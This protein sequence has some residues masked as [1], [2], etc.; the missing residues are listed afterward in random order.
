M[1]SRTPRLRIW[2]RYI[3][4]GDSARSPLLHRVPATE[5]HGGRYQAA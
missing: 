2:R 1:D 5:V 4:S 3:R